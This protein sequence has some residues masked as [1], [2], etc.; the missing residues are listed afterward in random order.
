MPWDND[1]VIS[2]PCPG[3]DRGH[4]FVSSRKEE[5]AV[6]LASSVPPAAGAELGATQPYTGPLQFRIHISWLGFV[7]AMG[8]VG[9]ELP[10]SILTQG[11]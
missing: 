11:S 5:P 4:C 9:E 1:R 10:P 6:S 7:L 8:T 3:T 2:V